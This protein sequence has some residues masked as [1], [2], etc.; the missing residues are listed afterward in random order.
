MFICIYL[1]QSYFYMNPAFLYPNLKCFTLELLLN[2]NT[3]SEI[4]NRSTKFSHST[5]FLFITSYY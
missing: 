5:I 3:M 4:R 2:Y 1:K